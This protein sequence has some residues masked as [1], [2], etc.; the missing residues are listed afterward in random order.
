MIQV[1]NDVVD[2][3]DPANAATRRHARFAERVCAAS[4]QAALAAARDPD[5]HLWSLFAAKEAAYK[6]VTKLGRAPGFAHRHLVVAEDLRS[7]SYDD[8]RLCLWL[9]ADAAAGVVHALASTGSQR[10]WSALAAIAPRAD[11]SFEA[12]QLLCQALAPRLGAAPEEL[13]VQRTER[14]GSWD[15]YGP[16]ELLQRDRPAPGIDISLSHDGRFVAVAAER[17]PGI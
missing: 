11:P 5:T 2:L 4:E 17:Q 14:P 10:P 15:G 16:P 3:T 8:L 13:S 1:G 6:V 7:V 12:R 9:H